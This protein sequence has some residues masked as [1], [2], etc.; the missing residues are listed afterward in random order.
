MLDGNSGK[1]LKVIMTSPRVD[2]IGNQVEGISPE[3]I[4][5]LPNT[6]DKQIMRRF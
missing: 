3:L 1:G 5:S 6:I 4:N 2:V